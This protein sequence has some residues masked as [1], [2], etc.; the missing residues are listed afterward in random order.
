MDRVDIF[1]IAGAIGV[2]FTTILYTL[3]IPYATVYF[4]QHPQF[5]ELGFWDA[6]LMGGNVFKHYIQYYYS[7]L[8]YLGAIASGIGIAFKARDRKNKN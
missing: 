1:L 3:Q 5:L 6:F 8:G 2:A 7:W 4:T